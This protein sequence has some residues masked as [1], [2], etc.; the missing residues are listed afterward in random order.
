MHE[1]VS[2]PYRVKLTFFLPKRIIWSEFVFSPHKWCKYSHLGTHLEQV[3]IYDYGNG[4]NT[5]LW[6][7]KALSGPI[8]LMVLWLTTK[9]AVT[10]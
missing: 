5:N 10:V 1:H 4:A 8:S 3:Q 2:A 6:G 9:P 7:L